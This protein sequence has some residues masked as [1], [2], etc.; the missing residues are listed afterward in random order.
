MHTSSEGHDWGQD[1]VFTAAWA[2]DL[3]FAGD[4]SPDVTIAGNLANLTIAKPKVLMPACGT[5]RYAWEMAERG[6]SIEASDICQ[7]MVDHAVKHRPHSNVEY[8]QADMCQPLGNV[9][10]CDAAFTFCNSFRYILEDHQVIGHFHAV[11]ARLKKDGRYVMELG[12]AGPGPG[13]V[14]KSVRWMVQHEHAT[15]RATW[16]LLEETPPMSMEKAVI[17][18]EGPGVE[19]QVFE[20]LQ[21]QR[22]WRPHE[23][24]AAVSQAGL[25]VLGYFSPAGKRTE[26][27]RLARYYVVMSNN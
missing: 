27:N 23:L 6:W 12:L 26:P 7:P 14:G 21:P 19:T 9:A 1:G 4:V 8:H 11:K 17:T 13:P 10:D 22:V 5:G 3:A 15:V 2:Y 16:T 24:E 18:V 20:A 25:N